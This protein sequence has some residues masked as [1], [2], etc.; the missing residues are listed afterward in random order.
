[1]AY[2]GSTKS[3]VVLWKYSTFHLQSVLCLL[4]R[5]HLKPISSSS[6]DGDVDDM[7]K[8]PKPL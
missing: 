6:D 3:P 4:R 5:V 2:A 7:E 8:I 1:M